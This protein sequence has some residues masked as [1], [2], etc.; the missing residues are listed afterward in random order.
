[1]FSDAAYIGPYIVI[2]S[3]ADSEVFLCDCNKFT[4]YH[5]VTLVVDSSDVSSRTCPRPR[6]A[7]K[8]K[9]CVLVL[10][11]VLVLV[12][13]YHVLGIGLGLETKSS[14]IIPR[15]LINSVHYQFITV[16]LKKMLNISY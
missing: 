4:Q 16:R 11:L 2:L 12:E 8:T 1:M 10:I 14:A 3:S 13:G 5:T 15:T 9:S 6:G 7:S